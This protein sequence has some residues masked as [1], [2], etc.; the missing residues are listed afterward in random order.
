[1]LVLVLTV[2]E[3]VRARV[4]HEPARPTGSEREHRAEIGDA[5]VRDPLL[6]AGE[7]VAA[8]VAVLDHRGG[9][10]LHRREIAAGVGLGRA[11]GHQ[12]ALLGDPRHPALLL[13]GR[14]ADGD[15]FGAEKRRQHGGRDAEIDRGHALA[16]PI[17]VDRLAAH[18]AELLRYEEQ[19]DAEL[20][21]AHAAHGLLGKLVALVELI[22]VASGSSRRANSPIDSSVK[23]S[24]S[25]SEPCDAAS[26]S[27]PAKRFRSRDPET[28]LDE[29]DVGDNGGN[30]QRSSVRLRVSRGSRAG[31]HG[32]SRRIVQT[33]GAALNMLV[34]SVNGGVMPAA[35]T[36]LRIAG[37]DTSGGFA[38]SAAVEHPR[39]LFLG[40]V[41]PVPGPWPIGNVLSP[42]DLLIVVGALILLHTTC[43]SRP[44]RAPALLHRT[45]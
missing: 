12:Q 25:V 27:D 2:G 45:G 22:S 29:S 16:D 3:P 36:A 24:V 39:L 34:I 42:G 10:R 21:A 33:I 20:L 1:M 19:L 32:G 31:L 23:S 18:P 4:D 44:T 30:P 17:D 6:G 9:R 8:H 14:A 7:L 41:I 38:N 5:A 11:V 40:D 28:N 35:H 37:I 26:S 43:R 15:R 13:L